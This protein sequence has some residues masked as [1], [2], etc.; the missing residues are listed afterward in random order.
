M[1]TKF[2]SVC[3]TAVL[4]IIIAAAVAIAASDIDQHRSCSQCG[5]DRNTFGYSRMLIH[6]T[7]G[8]Q[9]GICSINCAM[10]DLKKH[11]ENEVASLQ[12]AD[13]TTR[14][15]IDAK[16]A[17]WV[18]GGN[19]RG[20]MTAHPKWAFATRKAAEEFIATSGGTLSSWETVRLA[21]QSGN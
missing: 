1:K 5:M 21:A 11:A 19:K 12:V 10:I 20:V 3:I 9:T 6:Y 18:T 17:V 7:N 2:S 4:C 8:T 16:K 15:L 13:Y 14:T